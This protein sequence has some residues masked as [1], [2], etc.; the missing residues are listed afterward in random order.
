[1]GPRAFRIVVSQSGRHKLSRDTFGSE[2]RGL[3]E[4]DLATGMNSSGPPPAEE[5]IGRSAM[6]KRFE[7]FAHLLG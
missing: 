5:M 1:M 7:K 6:P 4:K 2:A 3:L